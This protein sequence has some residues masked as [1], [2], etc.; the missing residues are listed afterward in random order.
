MW[1]AL[2]GLLA[3]YCLARW[4]GYRAHLREL[5]RFYRIGRVATGRDP[6]PADRL[7]S[8]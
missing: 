1:L 7:K 6:I 3:I 2:A 5:D 4:L 8:P